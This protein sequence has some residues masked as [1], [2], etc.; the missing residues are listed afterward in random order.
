MFQIYRVPKAASVSDIRLVDFIRQNPDSI[1]AE[2]ISFASTRTPASDNMTRLALKDHIIEILKFVADALEV[3]Q[4]LKEQAAK[5]KGDG[6]NDTP[7]TKSAAEIH[8]RLRLENGFDIEQMVSEYRALRASV[9][10]QWLAR[11]QALAV[12]DLDDLTRFNEAIDQAMTESI[13]EY[14]KNINN[15]RNL[16]LGI[17]GHDLRNPIGAAS[18]AAQI[19]LKLGALA[20]KEAS[21]ASNIVTATDRATHI[22]NDLLEITRSSFGTEIPVVREPFSMETL[23]LEIRAEMQ[24]LAPRHT[25]ELISAGNTDGSWDKSRIGQIFSNLIG[26]AIQY[27]LPNSVIRL[28]LSGLDDE[29]LITV[30]NH[31]GFIPPEKISKIFDS[32]TRGEN[33]SEESEH[34]T[35]LGLG[36]FIAKKIVNAHRG[37]ISVVSDFVAGT[38]FT[39]Q[40]PKK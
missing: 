30:H 22:L 40:L 26:N 23:A 35:N 31:G 11:N 2:W 28:S 4:S 7:F 19:I 8:A 21:L 9:V 5:S 25:L 16:F 1:V 18:M 29:V 12:T 14:T 37:K 15:S 3:P 33:D 39:V 17:L 38:T 36:L 6:P 13:A 10:K 24:S 27:G 32:L 20:P 34:T